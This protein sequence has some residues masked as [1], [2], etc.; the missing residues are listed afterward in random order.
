MN[1]SST[2]ATER[3]A[4]QKANLLI[5]QASMLV[6]KARMLS[7]GTSAMALGPIGKLKGAAMIAAGNAVGANNVQI[8]K[9]LACISTQQSAW[10]T[11]NQLQAILKYAHGGKTTETLKQIHEQ[12]A[13]IKQV[14]TE[15]LQIRD[16]VRHAIPDILKLIRKVENF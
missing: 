4:L 7:R 14:E 8:I 13:L 1:I 9:Q 16:L 10:A 5:C 6:S 15:A 2:L 11:I 3:L 12:I